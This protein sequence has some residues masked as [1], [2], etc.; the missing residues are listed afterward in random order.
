[1]AVAVQESAITDVD[2]VAAATLDV[3]A[4]CHDLAVQMPLIE[5]LTVP[6]DLGTL[7]AIVGS[8]DHTVEIILDA[9][10]DP[11]TVAPAVW[12]LSRK[13]YQPVILVSLDQ[14]GYAHDGL[15]GT[16]C[17]LQ[18]WWISNE[19]VVFGASEST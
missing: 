15:R 3:Y 19:A 17:K 8:N 1:M 9:G 6:S 12:S 4:R 16:P 10:I 11:S 5:L 7:R 2:R 13:G 14:L 18:G